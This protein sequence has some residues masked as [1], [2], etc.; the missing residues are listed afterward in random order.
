MIETVIILMFVILF[1]IIFMLA[2][3]IEKLKNAA[4]AQSKLSSV[5]SEALQNIIKAVDG[6]KRNVEAIMSVLG[7][8]SGTK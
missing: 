2:S 4:I 6:N 8:L 1:V 7:R 3:Q 5:Q